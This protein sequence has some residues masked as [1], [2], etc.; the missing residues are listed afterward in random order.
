MLPYTEVFFYHNIFLNDGAL[1]PKIAQNIILVLQ[2]DGFSLVYLRRPWDVF[3]G[4][5]FRF[6]RKQ[7]LREVTS[8]S[9]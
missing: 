3:L 9:V 2:I 6:A 7:C 5:R 1:N 8:R 4:F